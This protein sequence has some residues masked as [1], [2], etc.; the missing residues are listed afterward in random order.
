L[1]S[2]RACCTYVKYDPPD[3][4]VYLRLSSALSSLV[5]ELRTQKAEG[6]GRAGAVEEVEGTEE[7]EGVEKSEGA[8]GNEGAE[9]TEELKAGNT[10]RIRKKQ[11]G[12]A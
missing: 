3:S 4:Q 8:D 9:E 12:L 10:E 6:A 2:Y 7:T 11:A 5:S 1:N